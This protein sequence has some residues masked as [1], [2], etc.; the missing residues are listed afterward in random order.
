MKANVTEKR[1]EHKIQKC[2]SCYPKLTNP[3]ATNPEKKSSRLE[4]LRILNFIYSFLVGI[5]GGF[6]CRK[7]TKY[8]KLIGAIIGLAFFFLNKRLLAPPEDE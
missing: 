7:Y 4:S 6:A 3:D 2:Q 1:I 8:H 5:V